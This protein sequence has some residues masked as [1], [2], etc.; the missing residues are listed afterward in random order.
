MY[1]KKVLCLANSRKPP[2]GRCIAVKVIGGSHEF[3]E[4][5]RPVSN[6]SSKEI[7]EEERRYEDGT[8]AQLLDI[9]TLPLI[10][11]KPTLHQVENVLIDDGYYW[12]KHSRA[13]WEQVLDAIDT[14]DADFWGSNHS[15]YYGV[16]DKVSESDLS[17]IGSSLKLIRVGDI[18]VQVMF[19]PGYE[20][21]PGRRRV[22]ARFNYRDVPYLFAITDPV[23]EEQYLR[24]ADGTY[25]LNDVVMCVSLAEP[26]NG[27]AHRLVASIITPERCA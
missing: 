4:W 20:G 26:W 6:R 9:L 1:T 27:N 2:S 10:E 16:N 11:A 24:M 18:Q 3:Q 15:T 25:E 19:E 5:I 7:S 14:Y 17:G 21:N 12:V 8:K 23:I 13:T 22:R